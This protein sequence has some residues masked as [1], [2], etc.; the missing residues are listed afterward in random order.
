MLLNAP[1]PPCHPSP[2]AAAVKHQQRRGG[3]QETPP[4]HRPAPFYLFLPSQCAFPKITHAFGS[5]RAG[6]SAEKERSPSASL[7][8]FLPQSEV[9]AEGKDTNTLP[10]KKRWILR[11][12]LQATAGASS[13]AGEKAASPAPSSAPRP[14]SARA[15][16]PARPGPLPRAQSRW[17]ASRLC[18]YKKFSRGG[19]R[20]AE[21]G[22]GRSPPVGAPGP[23][24]LGAGAG[25]GARRESPP[26]GPGKDAERGAGPGAGVGGRA[27][28]F[29]LCP[30]PRLPLHIGLPAPPALGRLL[31]PRPRFMRSLPGRDATAPG[32]QRRGGW[33]TSRLP[34]AP[35]SLRAPA[36]VPLR[37]P[38]EPPARRR[39]L[40]SPGQLPDTP[41]A[42]AASLPAS[43]AGSG[44]GSC[45][46]VCGGGGGEARS[47]AGGAVEKDGLGSRGP[48]LSAGLSQVAR[49]RSGSLAR[50]LPPSLSAVAPGAPL[51]LPPSQCGTL[52]PH[53]KE[54]ASERGGGATGERRTRMT[55]IT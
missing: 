18:F 15:A 46:G 21:V 47:G 19:G 50:S 39:S 54:R 42:A 24:A 40:L 12:L 4:Q 3:G 31:G 55:Q 43:R 26:P 48:G 38:G 44:S 23:A 49:S 30:P 20:G 37:T 28:G 2:A 27:P 5:R 41:P 16:A 51:A 33:G 25:E 10:W 8:A 17:G 35:P 7:L 13:C 11:L 22:C 45:P 52:S 1:P 36:C 53:S 14:A 34:S 29:L 9:A 6:R 32:G